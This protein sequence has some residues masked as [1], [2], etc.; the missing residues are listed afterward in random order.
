M[1]KNIKSAAEIIGM[2][3][4]HIF[5]VDVKLVSTLLTV[6]LFRDVDMSGGV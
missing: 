5:Q 2:Y 3:V 4:Q 6:V 1:D